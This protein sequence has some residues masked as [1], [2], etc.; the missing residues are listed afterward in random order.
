MN[1]EKDEIKFQQQSFNI[2]NNLLKDKTVEE[3]SAITEYVIKVHN[4]KVR[5]QEDDIKNQF[6]VGDRV[7]A[8]SN[9]AGNFEAVIIKIMTKNIRVRRDDLDEVW[10]MSPGLLEKI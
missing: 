4:Q 2:I 7:I 3:S 5:K 6:V 10:T 8:K 1:K 9:K